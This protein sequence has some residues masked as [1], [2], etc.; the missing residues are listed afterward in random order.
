MTRKA[1]KAS[2]S[3][4][5]HEAFGARVGAGILDFVLWF[6]LFIVAAKTF[7]TTTHTVNGTTS[8]TYVH[9]SGLP[10]LLFIGLGLLYFIVLEW[11]FGGTIGKLLLGIR[12]VNGNGRRITLK[13]S[14]IRNVLRVVD[15]FP[16]VPPYIAGLIFVAGDER[17]RR[18]GD[19]VAGTVV[20]QVKQSKDWL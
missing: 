10:F 1:T 6:V 9:L 11:Q 17:K 20:I 5:P 12:V 7:G 19:K 3:L 18:L 4:K 16:Y 14:A 13:Q 2:L 15:A 8:G